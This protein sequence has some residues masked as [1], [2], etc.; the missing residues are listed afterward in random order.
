MGSPQKTMR[1]PRLQPPLEPREQGHEV[2]GVVERLKED[3][4]VEGFPLEA[5]PEGGALGADAETHG[6]RLRPDLGERP[7]VDV[8][9][10]GPQA[11]ARQHEQELPAARAVLEDARVP[12]GLEVE[13]AHDL[14]PARQELGHELGVLKAPGDDLGPDV[15]QASEPRVL[16][17]HGVVGAPAAAEVEVEPHGERGVA[18]G[19]RVLAGHLGRERMLHV[20]RAE[21]L[22]LGGVGHAIAERLEAREHLVPA[23][24]RLHDLAP[25][26]WRATLPE[27]RVRAARDTSPPRRRRRRSGGRPRPRSCATPWTDP[28]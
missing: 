4:P 19:E 24:P 18:P 12:A 27:G 6:A 23:D 22:V 21:L 11:E 16:V 15:R 2:D 20:E 1:P 14:A 13:A 8:D 5:L 7:L 26:P 28:R 17:A 10:V 25:D 9:R 3:D